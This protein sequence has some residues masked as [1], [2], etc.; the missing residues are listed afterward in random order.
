MEE[1]TYKV[2]PIYTTIVNG[3]EKPE[4][5]KRWGYRDRMLH[6]TLDTFL[7]QTMSIQNLG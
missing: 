6:F 7:N 1:K 5:T 3:Q 4:C 2:I